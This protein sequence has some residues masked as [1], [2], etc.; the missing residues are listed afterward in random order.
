MGATDGQHRFLL[1]TGLGS[2]QAALTCQTYIFTIAGDVPPL[3]SASESS[4]VS[5]LPPFCLTR[6]TTWMWPGRSARGEHPAPY[7]RLC[8]TAVFLESKVLTK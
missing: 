1:S 7:F 2:D 6:G 8:S 4:T 5:L 3:A